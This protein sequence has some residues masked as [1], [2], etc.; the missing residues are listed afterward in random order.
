MNTTNE[1]DATIRIINITFDIMISRAEAVNP[2][3]AD[4][5]E[6]N[7]RETIIITLGIKKSDS[8]FT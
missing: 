3:S 4:M 2:N 6:Y 1:V 7:I 5:K 8:I